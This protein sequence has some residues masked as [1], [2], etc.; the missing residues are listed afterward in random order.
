[1]YGI[2]LS[3]VAHAIAT[4]LLILLKQNNQGNPKIYLEFS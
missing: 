4:Q 2:D 1:M 3:V